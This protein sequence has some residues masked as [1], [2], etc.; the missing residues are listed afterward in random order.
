MDD[1]KKITLTDIAEKAKV[2]VPLVSKVLNGKECRVS[3]IKREEIIR[4]ARQSGYQPKK[5]NSK[6]E[7]DNNVLAIIQPN[8]EYEFFC[9]LTTSICKIAHKRNYDTVIFYS[10]EDSSLE[11]KYLEWSR[12]YKVSGIFLNPCDNQINLDYIEWIR[13]CG[14]PIVFI[15]RCLHKIEGDYVTSDNYNASY[16]MTE[17]LIKKG[18]KSILFIL[19]GEVQFTN[20]VKDRFEG[21]CKAMMNHGLNPSKETIYCKRPVEYQPLINFNQYT[22]VVLST[23][24]DFLRMLEV[25]D[26]MRDVD[27][28]LDVA[29]F[30]GFTVP[31]KKTIDNKAFQC[32][33][34]DIIT[35]EQDI[36]KI[37]ENAVDIMIQRIKNK[38]VSDV[39]YMNMF[40]PCKFHAQ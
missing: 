33:N 15:D 25:V 13:R 5:H 18:H 16:K 26:L 4:L 1:R 20:V 34:K 40:I 37:A 19:H 24:T 39:K 21:Y 2:S 35:M 17:A 14:M 28:K 7:H 36:E 38:E 30:D 31:Y 29:A 12:E 11:R 10:N 23:S 9:S 27:F 3:E 32:I 6:E 8:L 22:A